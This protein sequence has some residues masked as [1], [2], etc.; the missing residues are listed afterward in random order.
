[1]KTYSQ[2]FFAAIAVSAVVRAAAVQPFDIGA[3]MEKE[4]FWSSDPVL[5]TSRHSEHG[6]EFTSDQREGAASRRD[7]AVTCFGIPVYESRVVFGR[8]GGIERVELMLYAAGGT[9]AVKEFTDPGGRRFRRL[10]RVERP[11][12]RE[13]FFDVLGKT[14]KRLTRP[15]ARPPAVKRESAGAF[16]QFSQTWPRTDVPTVSV[17]IWNYEQ[18]GK[19]KSTFSP[20]FIRLAVDGPAKLADRKERGGKTAKRKVA[21]GSG[22]ITD[23]V[24]DESKGRGD[25]FVDNVPMVDQG[26]KGYCA[27]ATAERVLRYYGLEIDEHSLADA[28]GTT[29]DGGTSVL[30]MKNSIEAVG[31]RYRLG[32]VVCYGDFDKGA[33]DRIAGLNAE[34]RAYNKAAKKLKKA[35]IAETVYITREGNTVY[36]NP[37]AFDAAADPEV[38]KEMKVN[39]MQ[40]SKFTRFK[41]DVRDQ[42]RKGIPLFW[43]VRLG[44]YP[45]PGIP[46]TAGGHMRLITGFNDKKDEI[47]YSD[48]WGAGH[49]LKRMPLE[50]AWTITDCLMYLK[51]L[52]R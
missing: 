28:A 5:F 9:E 31:K 4:T 2:I 14:R 24:I 16:R 15:R 47:L 51:P 37:A 19:D 20:G 6:F 3:D 36:Y 45:E 33:A 17:L 50:W 11:M 52:D 42:V 23:N 34:V 18:K 43:G 44:T 8:A 13:E 25:V 39:G 1:M 22:K 12:S 32:T 27:V 41:K 46:Q 49:E 48:S 26:Q 29:A 30:A 10:E 38:L 40:K 35:E 7:G 21:R